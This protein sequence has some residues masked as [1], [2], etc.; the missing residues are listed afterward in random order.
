MAVYLY[1]SDSR[2]KT[3]I[4]SIPLLFIIL[5]GTCVLNLVAQEHPRIYCS[6]DE[7]EA[8]LKSIA[9]TKWKSELVNKKKENLE[10]YLEIC[11]E[12]PE[13]LVSRLQMNWKTKHNKVYLQG[14]NFSHS[15]GTAPVP[16]VRFSGSR[17]WATDYLS[18]ELEEVEPY[19]DDERGMYLRHKTTKLKEW[20]H[21]SET[22]HIIES[23]NRKV[24]SLVQDAALLYWISGE[25]KYAEFAEPVFTKYIEGM[26]YRDPPVDLENGDQEG[27]SGLA[28]FE[29]IH[30]QIV[31]PLAISYDFLYQRFKEKNIELDKTVAVFQKWGDQI[32][33]KGIPDNNWNLFQARFLTYIALALDYNDTYENGKGQEYYLKN[34]FDISTERQ[35]AL[36]ESIL[37]YDQQNGIWPESASYSVHVTTTLLRILTL[38]DH[39]SNKNELTNF[40]IIEKAALAAFQYLFPS[41]YT[42]A[43]GDSKHTIL[44][45]ENFELLISN[46]RKYNQKEK[47]LLISGVLQNLIQEE[48]YERNFRD[49]YPLFFYVD[50]LEVD[51]TKDEAELYASLTSP[52]FYAPNVSL[53]IQRMG[54]SKNATMVSTVAS[55]G[56]HSHV[57]GI[58]MELFANGYVLAPDMGRGSSYWH[59][60]YR[61]YYSQFPA[62]NTVVVDGISTYNR[63]RG[64]HPFTLENHY[65]PHGNSDIEFKE[66]SFSNVSFVEPKTMSDQQRLTAIINSES[67]KGYVVDIFRSKKKVNAT[68]KHEYF[69]HNIGQSLDILD[70]EG[71]PLKLKATDELGTLHGDM[72]AYDYLSDK[73]SLSTSENI[74]ALFTL[75][76]KGQADNFM[77]MWIKGS[78][79]Q[80]VFTLKSPKSN[81]ISKGTA[82]AEVMGQK[83]PTLVL[84]KNEEAWNNPFVVVYNPYLAGGKQVISHVTFP[85]STH[86]S[87]SQIIEVGHDDGASRD[88]I[89]ANASENDIAENE[90]IYMKGLLALIRESQQGKDFIFVSG[91]YKFE[92]DGWE[93]VSSSSAVTVSIERN[94]NGYTIQNDKPVLIRIPKSGT[95]LPGPL[96]IYENGKMI[97]KREG[98]ISRHK[99]NLVEYRLAKAYEKAIVVNKNID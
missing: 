93:I 9:Q 36:K 82:P 55:W 1:D 16:T 68:Q 77:K 5:F 69:Y 17:D 38:L 25:E 74:N 31:I 51:N 52:T 97:A 32:I 71:Q 49:L 78:E 79:D 99:P 28:T 27:I 48:K 92:Y 14:G 61:E 40:P 22:G 21:P 60:D 7:K 81:A 41:G 43:F 53:F 67:G 65:P 57:N 23:I 80:K 44:P 72:K 91:S 87:G 20:V 95:N 85:E 63:M 47:E 15:E 83:I 30:E 75:K 8:F 3:R 70:Y 19:F 98:I 66:V 94:D 37:V 26:Y 88:V 45:P 33:N 42:V 39:T 34:I 84:R 56:N 50:K 2:M 73:Q 11:A 18:P 96:E 62:H 76:N 58:A 29:V 35:I 10:K 12:D 13:W 64:Y 6:K 46:Y 4:R 59:P 54:E 89:I 90:D 86:E 24:M